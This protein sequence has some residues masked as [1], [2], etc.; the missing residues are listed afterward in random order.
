[1][2]DRVR[3]AL[4]L[5]RWKSG[6]SVTALGYVEI[7]VPFHPYASRRGRVYEHRLVMERFLGRFLDPSEVVHHID[8]D[9]GNNAFENLMLFPNSAEHLHH[10][11]TVRKEGV[12][13][14]FSGGNV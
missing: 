14:A 6:R 10:H 13:K 3:R 9:R 1:M 11:A 2:K 7:Y 5:P 8:E 12:V 4:G